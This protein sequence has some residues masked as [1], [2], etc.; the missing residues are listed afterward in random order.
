MGIKFKGY[1]RALA[2]QQD[3][4][5][6]VLVG[7]VA[8]AS[9]VQVLHQSKGGNR[10]QRLANIKFEHRSLPSDLLGSLWWQSRTEQ[11]Q[12]PPL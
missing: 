5:V 7:E 6:R 2:V 3:L 12:T 11:K 8:C 1:L 4:L 10:G 9:P